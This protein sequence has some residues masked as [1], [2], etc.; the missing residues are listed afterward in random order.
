MTDREVFSDGIEQDF[1]KINDDIINKA[2]ATEKSKT[3]NVQLFY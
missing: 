2:A 1:D 3:D